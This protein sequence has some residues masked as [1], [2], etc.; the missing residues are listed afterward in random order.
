M[1][2]SR[3]RQ[4]KLRCLTQF[5]TGSP[6]EF[7]EIR[8]AP[9][10]LLRYLA[11]TSLFVEDHGLASDLNMPALVN[12]SILVISFVRKR[13]PEAVTMGTWNVR[14]I[15]F[16]WGT[17]DG[18]VG[19]PEC[20]NLILSCHQADFLTAR[21]PPLDAAVA[22]SGSGLTVP[23]L[24]IA[25]RHY[26][27]LDTA[28]KAGSK[29]FANLDDTDRISSWNIVLTH[30]A[31]FASSTILAIFS[32]A[33]SAVAAMKIHDFIKVDLA[34]Y[35]RIKV[36]LPYICLVL[37]FVGGF[38]RFIYWAV[39]PLSSR[40]LVPYEIHLVGRS[41]SFPFSLASTLLLTFYWYETVTVRV[42]PF[43]GIC[44]LSQLTCCL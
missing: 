44:P 3:L 8:N 33:V 43:E 24:T 14:A 6:K 35:G 22:V 4:V 27:R 32:C 9:V 23:V 25:N 41:G 10:F 21:L 15:L 5:Q 40:M 7:A 29:L 37:E 42:N 20:T 17:Y 39:D 13:L 16:A 34:N 19:F 38:L 2:G 12:G 18:A 28:R 1:P 30:P 26:D 36:T 11:N 31:F